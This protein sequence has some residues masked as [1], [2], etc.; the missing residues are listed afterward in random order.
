MFLSSSTIR[1]DLRGLQNAGSLIRAHGGAIEKTKTGFEL[2]SR[3]KEVQNLAEKQRITQAAIGLIEDGDRIILD[4][5]TTTLELAKR[6]GQR[7]DIMVV[8]NDLEIAGTL[9]DTEWLEIV[10]MGG[11]LRKKFHCTIGNQGKEMLSG[12]TVD[13]A[14][15]GTDSFSLPGRHFCQL[16]FTFTG[17]AF[18]ALTCNASRDLLL[19]DSSNETSRCS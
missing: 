10:F 15:M 12:L 13:K 2:D 16:P 14:F 3:H 18:H 7:K 8:T 4:T 9:E 19:S 11:I 5:G 1:G 6:L 17:G